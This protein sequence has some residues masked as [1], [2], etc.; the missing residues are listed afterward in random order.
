M[1]GWLAGLLLVAAPA[2]S[3]PQEELTLVSEHPV[4][5]MVGGNLSGLAFCG[6]RLWT[7]SDRDDDV[8][9][10]LDTSD[11][12]WKA[13]ANA[14]RV[15]P[16]PESYLPEKLQSL[17]RLSGLVRGGNLDFEGVSCDA[18]GNRYV[19]SEAFALVLKV[20]VEGAPVWL[21][22]PAALVEQARAKGMLQHFNGIF[23]G[24]AINPAGDRLWLAAEREQRGLLVVSRQ[25]DTWQCQGSCVLRAEPGREALPKQVGGKSVFRDFSDL[26][27]FDGKLYALERSAYRICRRALETGKTERCWS[28]AREALQPNR[29]YRQSYGLTEALVVDETGAWVGTDNNFGERA[30]GEKRPVVWRFAAPQGGWGVKP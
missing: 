3:A 15:P 22:L 30:D 17:A 24:I 11:T 8:L 7:V 12:V 2:F 1:R 29:L 5:G 19:V 25:G 16:L 21:D 20:P 4:D 28:F 9:Y 23:E 27:L 18:A 14:I 6:D 10:S 26:S 13:Q